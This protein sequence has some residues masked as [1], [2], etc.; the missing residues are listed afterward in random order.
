MEQ[1]AEQL[2][3]KL[4]SRG[5][6]GVIGLQRQFKIMDDDNSKSLS[7]YEFNKAMTDYMLGFSAQENAALFEYFDV[8]S[9]GSISY[10]EFIRAVRG[11]M[12]MTRKKIVAQAFKKLDKD[13]NGW[14]D[15][16]DVRGVYN[17]RKHPDV[18]SGKKTEDQILQEFLETFET[19]HNMRN[20]NAP[21]YVVTKEEFEEYYN[22][23]SCSIDDDMYF[24]RMMNNAWKLDEESRR[25]M[26]TKGWTQEAAQPR[27]KGDNNIFN[28][29]V[30]KA[31]QETALDLNAN[32]AQV[33]EH[34]RKRIA[35]RGARGIAGIGKNFKIAD[36]DNSKSLDR[37]EFKKAMHDFRIGLSDAQV[38]TAFRIFDRDGSGS[39]SYDEFLRSIRG[40]MNAGRK[41]LAQRVYKIMDAD[42][43]GLDI[44]DIRQTY[45]AKHH[46][47]V[48]SGKKTEDEVL[49]EFLDT[50]E[51]HWCDMA[52]NADSRDGIVTMQDW[53]EYYNNVSMSID[54]DEYFALMMNNAWNLDGKKV[55]KKGW[56]AEF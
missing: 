27:A 14:I 32:E 56:G 22:N 26:G 33:M 44:N 48:K 51:D 1:L 12:N 55:T 49:T 11:P 4:A 54:N 6:R 31:P 5:A 7:K 13:G 16:N 19:A 2:K 46:P 10:D 8:D 47:D 43:S 52:G 9:S 45:N 38:Q 17:G 29:P 53:L 28:R 21:D 15:I 41:A 25:G 20:N 39:I 35:A 30:Q 42:G 23:I 24:L 36:D 50:F 40:E 37:Q 3:T 18:I 34:V